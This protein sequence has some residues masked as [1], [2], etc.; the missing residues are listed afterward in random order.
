MPVGEG[1]AGAAKKGIEGEAGV[2]KKGI[3]EKITEAIRG[4][5]WRKCARG[6]FSRRLKRTIWSEHGE[7]LE[8][9]AAS[10]AHPELEAVGVLRGAEN[11]RGEE[12]N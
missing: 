1:A 11:R 8:S 10:G 3:I 4:E 7:W 2:A 6:N 12:G 5:R 9:R